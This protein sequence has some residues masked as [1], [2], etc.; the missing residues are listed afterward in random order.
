MY[1]D[2]QR[3][4]DMSSIRDAMQQI[5][6]EAEAVVDLGH[7]NRERTPRRKNRSR[8]CTNHP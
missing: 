5:S 6:A 7:E 8:R 4:E 1:P 3:L 2:S